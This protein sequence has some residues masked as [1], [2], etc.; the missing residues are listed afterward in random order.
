MAEI[1]PIRDRIVVKKIEEDTKT[2]GGLT[3]P[4]G[5]VERPTKG[6][7]IAVGDG[8]LTDDGKILPM[9]VKKGDTVIYPKYSGHPLKV[10]GD[11]FLILDENEVLGFLR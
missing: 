11:E 3:L 9:V 2:K 5:S 7:V 6:L 10:N 1:V 8:K 4:D